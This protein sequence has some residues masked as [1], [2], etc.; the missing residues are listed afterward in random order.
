MSRVL[1]GIA[2]LAVALVWSACGAVEQ[3]ETMTLEA[4]PFSHRVTAEGMLA[5]ARVTPISVPSEVEW[6]VRLAWVAEDGARVREGDVVARFDGGE[7]K[8]QLT[9]GR[10]EMSTVGF[11]ISKGEVERSGR[12]AEINHDLNVAE[13][14]LDVAQRFELEDD[15][16][17]SRHEIIESQIDGALAGERRDH[18]IDSR[19]THVSLT[20]TERAL[21]AIE[22]RKAQ[23]KIS[24]AEDGLLALD[25]R[26]PHDGL[27]TLTRNWQGEPMQIGTELWSGQVIAEIPDL[28]TLEAKVYVLEA[29]AGGLE[30]GRS[31][32]VTV[33]A[34]PDISYEATIS[35]VD[36]V[37]NPRFRGSPVQYFGVTLVFSVGAET[38]GLKPGQRLRATLLL[39]E[40]VQAL[41]VPRHAVFDAEGENH[42]WVRTSSGFTARPVEIGAS[43]MGSVELTD[44]VEAGEVIALQ[45]PSSD[46]SESASPITQAQ[47]G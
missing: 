31:A 5:S 47:N 35:K 39:A 27:L 20:Q 22:E 3:V 6:R 33:E 15:S 40:K 13:L 46:E 43:S 14:E 4:G 21:L 44:G 42:V 1:A 8:D 41:V 17:F 10:S 30:V 24:Q 37:A 9:D 32:T 25:V 11:R 26:A 12:S 23:L 29:D 45:P 34:R 28:A 36:A 2:L 18:A 16:V 7:M 38:V 19:A